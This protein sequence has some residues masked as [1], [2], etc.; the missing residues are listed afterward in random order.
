L[1][2]SGGTAVSAQ[3][4]D[5]GGATLTSAL[6]TT[7]N[8]GTWYHLAATYGVSGQPITVWVNGVA[9]TPAT[10]SGTAITLDRMLVGTRLNGGSPGVFANGDIAEAAVWNDVLSAA[11][12]AALAARFRPDLIKPQN[13]SLYLDLIRTA[14]DRKS[15]VSLTP[16]GGPTISPHPSRIG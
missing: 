11:E 8:A 13:L 9:G 12:I 10:N 14:R 7:I 3:R 5:D 4:I 2:Q 6:S 15:G 16:S 1:F